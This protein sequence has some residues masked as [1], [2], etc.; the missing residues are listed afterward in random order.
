[1]KYRPDRSFHAPWAFPRQGVAAITQMPKPNYD[2]DSAVLGEE[3]DMLEM[4]ANAWR[5]MLRVTPVCRYS[6]VCAKDLGFNV[7]FVTL[8]ILFL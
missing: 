4:R 1:M 5:T 3:L 7:L 6:T 8:I 2:L